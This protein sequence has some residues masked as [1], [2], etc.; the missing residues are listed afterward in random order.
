MG[1]GIDPRAPSEHDVGGDVSR[2]V[3]GAGRPGGRGHR[4]EAPHVPGVDRAL[5]IDRVDSPI[6]RGPRRQ[7]RR[8]KVNRLRVRLA[9]DM[10]G[11]AEVG[12]GAE[13]DLLPH[14][15]GTGVPLQQ[16]QRHGGG[17]VGRLRVVGL[18]GGVFRHADEIGN[19]DRAWPRV[20][21]K[22]LA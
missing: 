6:V 9:G 5:G 2:A 3:H 15:G 16:G 20:S 22:R 1:R 19:D 7:A 11:R 13:V 10:L 8:V 4:G 12:I 17:A 21:S 14:G 18:H